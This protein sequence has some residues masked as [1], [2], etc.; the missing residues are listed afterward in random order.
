MKAARLLTAAGLAAVLGTV[1]L[2]STAAAVPQVDEHPVPA[3]ERKVPPPHSGHGAQFDLGDA[4]V[5][6]NDESA[7]PPQQENSSF[8][9]DQSQ[10]V[11]VAVL[12]GILIL[13]GFGAD[14][15]RRRGHAP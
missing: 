4:P 15:T 13:A 7:T 6:L 10:E 12:A 2:A 3:A 1:G 8:R 9:I 5:V 11:L 14:A